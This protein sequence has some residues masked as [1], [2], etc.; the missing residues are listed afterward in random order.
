[1]IVVAATGLDSLGETLKKSIKAFVSGPIDGTRP[2][3]EERK[4][5]GVG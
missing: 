4:L 2:Q 1:L 3:D 5:M